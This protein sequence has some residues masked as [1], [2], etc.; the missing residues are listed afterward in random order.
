MLHSGLCTLPEPI[1]TQLHQSQVPVMTTG[2]QCKRNASR[3]LPGIGIPHICLHECVSDGIHA[4]GAN[5]WTASF[6]TAASVVGS[7]HTQRYTA[8]S[9]GPTHLHLT[10]RSNSPRRRGFVPPLGDV[11]LT[12]LGPH[13]L[14]SSP[15]IHAPTVNTLDFC[16]NNTSSEI[17]FQINKSN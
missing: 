4:M 6:Y 2:L 8:H 17:N 13:T 11:D 3:I 15:M 7:P 10:L 9:K 1:P 12:T 16:P 14:F 5:W